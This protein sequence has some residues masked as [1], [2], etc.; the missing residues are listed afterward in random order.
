MIDGGGPAV[1]ETV[2]ES[3]RECSGRL[4]ILGS[5]LTRAEEVIE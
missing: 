3:D 1:N 5:P 2:A 4:Q